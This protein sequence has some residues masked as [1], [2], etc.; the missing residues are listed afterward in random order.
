KASDGRFR[1]VEATCLENVGV[2]L[3]KLGRAGE[4]VEPLR[5]ALAMRREDRS[6]QRAA[7]GAG[8]LAEA[9]LRVGHLPDALAAAASAEEELSRCAK[10][11][12]EVE[13]AGARRLAHED[14][15]LALEAFARLGRADEPTT[16]TLFA[17]VERGHAILLAGGVAGR[18]A[19][20]L[21]RL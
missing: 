18:S 10:G 14:A 11:L 2:V 12:G 21:A 19:L 9:H 1:D 4:A 20:R 5:S 16:E 8:E 3:T 6:P 15:G 17:T 13:A 7:E